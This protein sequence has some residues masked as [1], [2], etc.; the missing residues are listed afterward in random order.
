MAAI[1]GAFVVGV[2]V[3]DA[4]KNGVSSQLDGV[5]AMFKKFKKS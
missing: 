3:L 1:I 5:A 4:T 2:V